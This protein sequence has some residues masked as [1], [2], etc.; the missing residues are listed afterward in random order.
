M[1][2]GAYG[3]TGTWEAYGFG[4]EPDAERI[5]AELLRAEPDYFE[6]LDQ[7]GRALGATL[8]SYELEVELATANEDRDLGYLM[9]GEGKVSGIDA[10]W[11]GL[12]DGEPFVELRTTWKLG[13]IFGFGDTPDWPLLYGYRIDIAGDPNVKVKLSFV[14]D[15]MES[16][17]I[18]IGTAL[19]A[20]NAIGHVCRARPGVVGVADLPLVTAR[21][22]PR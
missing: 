7:I 20:I 17:D 3:G 11:I 16:F 15:D 22:S 1:D 9:I 6:A 4:S 13:A 5:R 21:R 2:C 10:R 12:V 14:P 18:G 19:P 8:D